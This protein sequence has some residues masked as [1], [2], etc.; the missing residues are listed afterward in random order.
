MQIL[1][2]DHPLVAARTTLSRNGEQVASTTNAGEIYV[3]SVPEGKADFRF[4]STWSRGS[5]FGLS[6]RTDV[7]FSF[8]SPG[9]GAAPLRTVR[10]QAPVDNRNTVRR[11][12][13][14]TLSMTIVGSGP[15]VRRTSV[16]VSGDNGR[17]WRQAAVVLGAQGNYKVTF[18]TPKNAK[19]ISLKSELID[20]SGNVSSQ[21]VIA[22]YLLR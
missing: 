12:P 16:Q 8:T 7:A 6:T 4:T 19:N 21:T 10:Y 13:V 22:A 5:A 3:R 14:S 1:V 20:K 9:D 18:A 2:V 11:T 15:A 17:T